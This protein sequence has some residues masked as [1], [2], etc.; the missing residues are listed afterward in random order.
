MD[1]A[2]WWNTRGQMGRLGGL[3]VRRGFPRTHH[4]AQARSVFAVAGQR[5]TELFDPPQSVTLWRLPPEVEAQFD[6]EW[7]TWLDDATAWQPFF[8][9]CEQASS[10]D[11][12]ALLRQFDCVTDEDVARHSRTRR[13][14][15]GRSVQL[16]GTFSA[17][18]ED[19]AA[20]ALGFARGEPGS[21]AVP[22]MLEGKP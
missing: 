18:D 16:P 10:D 7:E 12:V 9:Q 6:A 11:L 2:R 19:I 4:F 15:E 20:L 21:P 1:N 13:S 5:C 22:Y 14:S 17:T 3:A 8:Q